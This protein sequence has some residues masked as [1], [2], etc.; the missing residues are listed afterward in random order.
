MPH[1]KSR[2]SLASSRAQRSSK[3][4][5]ENR[6]KSASLSHLS[7]IS[8]TIDHLGAQGDGIVLSDN[9]HKVPIYVPHSLPGEELVVQ[10]KLKRS[11]GIEA[12]I[13]SISSPSISRKLAD[14]GA[15]SDCGGCQF[16]YAELGFYHDWKEQLCRDVLKS[17]GIIPHRWL[18]PFRAERHSRRRARFAFRRLAQNTVFG[19]R[20]RSSHHIVTLTGCTILS[21][22]ILAA[23]DQIKAML[24]HAIAVGEGGEVEVNQCDNGLDVTLILSHELS[25]GAISQLVEMA[26]SSQIIRLSCSDGKAETELLF[27]CEIP[28]LAWEMPA[29][30]ALDQLIFHPPAGAFLQSVYAAE[31]IMRQDCYDALG[32]AKRI[33]D[34]FSGSGA[35]G[36]PLAFCPQPPKKLAAYDVSKNAI[37]ALYE[38]VKRMAPDLPVQL[39]AEAR[40]LHVD[41]MTAKELADYDAAILDPPRNG[42]KQQMPALAESGISRIVMVSCHLNSFVRDGRILME[43][44]YSC[45]WARFIDQFHLTTHTELVACFDLNVS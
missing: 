23:L 17:A 4:K 28:Q 37:N 7:P 22:P 43:A 27:Q 38:M 14:C 13:I 39:I 31:Q 6:K 34:L 40:N 41:P 24:T 15:A 18:L 19:F 35:L 33:I 10:P 11:N 44:G 8:V 29:D 36:L 1:R 9:K 16:Q 20:A 26:A 12:E 21:K 32:G 30:A 25:A 45:R 42:A 5:T 3:G 2:S